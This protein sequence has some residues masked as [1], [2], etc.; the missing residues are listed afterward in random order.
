ME[1]QGAQGRKGSLDEMELKDVKGL[2]ERKVN[3]E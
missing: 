3:T 2:K 1:L